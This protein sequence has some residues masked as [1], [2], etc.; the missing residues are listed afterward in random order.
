MAPPHVSVF[1]SL[2]G[3][4]CYRK[5]ETQHAFNFYTEV[6]LDQFR[7]ITMRIG[8]V[9]DLKTKTETE[10][11]IVE[12]GTSR[13]KKTHPLK[14]TSKTEKLPQSSSIKIYR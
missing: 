3:G 10:K 1:L 5:Q 13:K 12:S 9:V 4:I 7:M 14:R 6:S 2:L 8:K 11:V